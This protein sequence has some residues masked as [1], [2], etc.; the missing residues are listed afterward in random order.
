[1]T[2]DGAALEPVVLELIRWGARYMASGPGNDRSDPRWA[3]LALR[4]LLEGPSASAG[5]PGSLHLDIDSHP[6][7]ITDDG[8]TRRVLTG[9]HGTP[10]ATATVSMSEVLAVAAGMR[11]WSAISVAA[12][13]DPAIMEAAL[14]ARHGVR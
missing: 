9:H 11:P 7:T 6:M 4:A 8:K 13:G 5:R 1:L 12:H 14:T 2:T 10:G 3:T